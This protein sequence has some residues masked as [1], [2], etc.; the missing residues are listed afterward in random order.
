MLC[1]SCNKFATYN[2]DFEPE[3]DVEVESAV[4]INDNAEEEITAHVGGSV[5]IVLASECCGDELKEANLD[6]EQDVELTRA[7]GCDCDLTDLKVEVSGEISERSES[8]TTKTKKD[9]TVVTKAIPYR[10]QKRYYGAALTLEVSCRCG[11]TKE[12]ADWQDDVQA[13]SMDELV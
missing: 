8:T 10:Y 9:G 12:S 4:D 3:A 6:I 1:P 13:S 7:E 11:K 5:R 2:L